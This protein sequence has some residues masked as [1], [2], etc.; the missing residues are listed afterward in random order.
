MSLNIR[1]QDNIAIVKISDKLLSDYQREGILSPIEEKIDVGISLFILDLSE[2]KLINSSGLGILIT[3]LTKARKAGGE[4]ILTG[5]NE[6]ISK[7]LVITKLTAVFTTT[8]TIE[9]GINYLKNT[10]INA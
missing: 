3:I 4:A 8:K 9:E 7:L 10:L 1:M 6:Q 5:I 2:L